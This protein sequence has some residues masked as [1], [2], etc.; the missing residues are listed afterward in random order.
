MP[1]KTSLYDVTEHS[2]DQIKNKGFAYHGRLFE[3][4]MSHFMFAEEKR[5]NILASLEEIYF[6]MIERVKV[7]KTFYDFARRKNDRDFN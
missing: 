3:K 1:L 4:T 7:I 2:R 5:T 6:E